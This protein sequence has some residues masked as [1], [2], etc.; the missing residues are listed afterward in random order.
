MGQATQ[1]W[2]LGEAFFVIVAAE[3]PPSE[4]IS[5]LVTTAHIEFAQDFA[6]MG[7][8]GAQGN[9][10]FSDN[11]RVGVS[12][13]GQRSDFLLAFGEFLP[14]AQVLILGAVVLDNRQAQDHAPQ[15]LG[16]VFFAIGHLLQHD[17]D[18]LL[19]GQFD[20]R[21]CPLAGGEQAVEDVLE[22]GGHVVGT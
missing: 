3:V 17:Q 7:L 4:H 1:I 16:A 9:V 11:F 12:Q 15:F 13:A 8:D 21:G 6:D 10:Q 19:G 5:Q 22:A 18:I 20:G 2:G 14:A